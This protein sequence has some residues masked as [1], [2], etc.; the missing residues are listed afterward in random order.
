VQ[1]EDSSFNREC[2]VKSLQLGTDEE[3]KHM[4]DLWTGLHQEAE[5]C[6]LRNSQKSGKEV[7]LSRWT[8]YLHLLIL[9]ELGSEPARKDDVEVGAVYSPGMVAHSE[10][11]AS[12]RPSHESLQGFDLT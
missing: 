7:L 5:L 10:L 12:C 9:D 2:A 8:P 3:Y 11:A 6:C 4:T 1:F